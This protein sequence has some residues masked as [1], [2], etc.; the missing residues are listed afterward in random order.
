MSRRSVAGRDILLDERGYSLVELLAATVAGLLVSGAALAIII[1]ALTFSINDGDRA[2]ADQQAGVA[3]ERIVQALNSSCVVGVGVSP[4]VGVTASTAVT[5]STAAPAS[6]GNS[7]TFYS[8]LA[9]S[10][11]ISEPNEIVVYLSSANGPLDMATYQYNSTGPSGY[12]ATPASTDV[13]LAHAD[14]PGSTGATGSTQPIFTYDGYDPTTGTLSDQYS[15]SPS[16]GAT[17]AARTAEVG[18]A[19]QSQPTDG[20]NPKGAAVDLSDQVVLRLSAVSDNPT[21]ST[22][23]TGVSPCS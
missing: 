19:F 7:L 10:P 23:V 9:D 21:L 3:M 22:G 20:N 12:S 8:S 18:I 13:L 17:N 4:L 11:T 5:G 1:S 6:S 2:D 15:S 16:L 14:P